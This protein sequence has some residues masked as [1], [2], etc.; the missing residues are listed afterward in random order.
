MERAMMPKMLDRIIQLGC[1]TRNHNEKCR[2]NVCRRYRCCVPPRATDD[3]HLYR[4]PYDSDDL[5]SD[6]AAIVGKVAARLMKVAEASS[7]ARG[8]PS[9]FA[10]KPVPD[11]LDLAKPLHFAALLTMKH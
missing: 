4:C 1:S 5:W 9:P 11:H 8:L 6:R 3:A 7:D 2:R 10:L